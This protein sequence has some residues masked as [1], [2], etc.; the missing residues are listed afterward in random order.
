MSDALADPIEEWTIGGTT[1]QFSKFRMGSINRIQSFLTNSGAPRPAVIR[2]DFSGV[3]EALA[4]PQSLLEGLTPEARKALAEKAL[5]QAAD[6]VREQLNAARA[7]VA[8]WPPMFGTEEAMTLLATAD[9]GNEFL[10]WAML[11]QQQPQVTKAEAAAILEDVDFLTFDEIRTF[12]MLGE[13]ALTQLRQQRE[14]TLARFG[15]ADDEP[16]KLASET[17]GDLSVPKEPAGLPT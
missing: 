13:K 10:F 2:Q 15:L 17:N 5:K 11:R 8:S 4:P 12:C 7:E 6:L 14:E 3:A 9:G 1:Y 16:G